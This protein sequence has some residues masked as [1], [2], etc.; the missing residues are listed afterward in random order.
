[1]EQAASRKKGLPSLN[2][3][4]GGNGSEMTFAESPLKILKTQSPKGIKQ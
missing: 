4:I 1:M 2:K 3:L